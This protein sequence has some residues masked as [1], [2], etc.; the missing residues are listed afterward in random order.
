ML[1]NFESYDSFNYTNKRPD[2][3]KTFTSIHDK[4]DVVPA[5]NAKNNCFVFK[6]NYMKCL[7]SEEDVE[8]T[9]SNKIYI[10]TTFQR[11]DIVTT[12]MSFYPLLITL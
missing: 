1:F 3:A 7:L 9:C 11:G 6:T 4:Y 2:V 5:D 10:A 8:N 12:I